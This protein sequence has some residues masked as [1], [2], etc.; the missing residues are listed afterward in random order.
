LLDPITQDSAAFYQDRALFDD[1]K[2]I[3][4]ETSEG[5]RIAQA[6]GDLNYPKQ[7]L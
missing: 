7:L 1:F 6:L 3:V 2:G 5:K 4:L